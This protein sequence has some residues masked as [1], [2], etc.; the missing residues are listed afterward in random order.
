[1]END[2]AT[3]LGKVL[4]EELAKQPAAAGRGPVS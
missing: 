2:T 3:L 1:M 4:A